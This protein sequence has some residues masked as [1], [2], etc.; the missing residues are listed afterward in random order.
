MNNTKHSHKIIWLWLL[1]LASLLSLLASS[2]AYAS[3]S[4]GIDPQE[5]LTSGDNLTSGLVASINNE[6]RNK[7]N[8]SVDFDLLKYNSVDGTVTFDLKEYNDT[9]LSQRRIIMKTVLKDISESNLAPLQRNKL[10]NFVS[11]QDTEISQSLTLLQG[12]T[13]DTLQQGAAI[14]DPLAKM[15]GKGIGILVIVI[16]LFLMLGVVL[17]L[18]YMT[19]PPARILLDHASNGKPHL[20]SSEAKYAIEESE[21]S[22][23]G[24]WKGYIPIY[25]RT[26]ILS[27]YTI[28]MMLVLVAFGK[29]WEP[30]FFLASAFGF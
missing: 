19:T 7:D 4:V 1:A 30:L 24:N 16:M 20:I 27:T 11:E 22:G 26:R 29:I 3:N 12:D 9:P 15:V 23:N 25:L 14:V 2:P 21:S 5:Q 28:V 8:I 13:S 17:D 18:L 6:L 10:Y